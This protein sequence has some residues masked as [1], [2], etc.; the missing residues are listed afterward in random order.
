[1]QKIT[2]TRNPSFVATVNLS[3]IYTHFNRLKKKGVGNIVEKGKIAQNEQFHLI[4][5][6][7]LC[8][9]YPKIL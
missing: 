7:F 9:I 6:C 1:M 4:P 5:Q 3:S 8:N 2:K